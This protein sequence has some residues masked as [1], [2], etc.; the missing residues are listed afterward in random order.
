MVWTLGHAHFM[1]FT[2]KR[3]V[4][5]QG[6]NIHCTFLK[7]SDCKKRRNAPTFYLRSAP[8]SIG[9]FP[10][11]YRWGKDEC[12]QNLHTAAKVW[13]CSQFPMPTNSIT[14]CVT[15]SISIIVLDLVI[16]VNKLVVTVP[17]SV[18]KLVVV[19]TVIDLF[20]T[21]LVTLVEE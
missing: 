15:I 12:L 21:L 8:P 14:C 16:A 9:T 4:F 1:S 19:N 17:D 3:F 13:T 7:C 11:L 18:M 6:I 20:V 5:L 10:I 2:N